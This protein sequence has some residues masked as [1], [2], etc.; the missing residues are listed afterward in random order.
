M[1]T[2]QIARVSPARIL[3]VEDEGLI[4]S[5]IEAVLKRAGYKISGIAASSEE[6]FA[7]IEAQHPDLILMDV[8]ID[9]PLDGI[10]TVAKLRETFAIPIIY[11]SAQVNRQTLDRARATGTFEFLA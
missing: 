10:Q 5:D 9:G 8:H 3:I 7:N 4:A 11:L 2:P 1:G 6:V